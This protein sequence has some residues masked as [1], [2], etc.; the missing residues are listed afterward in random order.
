[1]ETAVPGPTELR[2]RTRLDVTPDAVRAAL[3]PGRNEWLR[4]DP[5]PRPGATDLERYLIDLEMPLGDRTSRVSLRKAAL[6]DVGRVSDDDKGAACL[7]ISWQAA[8]LAPLFPVF[9]GHICWSD[10]ELRLDGW[11]EAPGGVVGAA[12]DQLLFRIV[13]R[14]T[15]DWLLGRV[16]DAAERLAADEARGT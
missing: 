14:R 12:A 3:G 2:A 11:Y 5:A 9:S 4:A 6:V 8:S 1:M 16:A 13:A 15:A 7:P 10:G